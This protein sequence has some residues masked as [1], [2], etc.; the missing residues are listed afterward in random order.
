MLLIHNTVLGW[1]SG[2]Y[3][4]NCLTTGET[5]A[6][7]IDTMSDQ[8][9]PTLEELVAQITRENRYR[10]NHEGWILEEP[11]AELIAAALATS[12]SLTPRQAEAARRYSVSYKEFLH[13]N[14]RNNAEAAKYLMAALEDSQ[15]AFLIAVKK[16]LDARKVAVV[17]DPVGSENTE[18]LLANHKGWT[19]DRSEKLERFFKEV[20]VLTCDHKV[21]GNCG[22]IYP[23]DLGEALNRV[24]PCWVKNTG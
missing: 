17:A 12:A 1:I 23:S 15:T 14:L 21:F 18:D 13:Q 20:A 3:C 5:I 6:F 7:W 16:F 19:L 22:V 9:K 10:E 2:S 24:D 4:H 11:H 8:D